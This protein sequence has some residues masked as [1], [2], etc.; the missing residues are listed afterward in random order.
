MDEE[1]LFRLAW[2]QAR[3]RITSDFPTLTAIQPETAFPLSGLFRVTAVAVLFQQGAHLGLEE[4]QVWSRLESG[5]SG[6]TDTHGSGQ[7]ENT[8]PKR[9]SAVSLILDTFGTTQ[10]SH[11]Q[12]GRWISA[13]MCPKLVIPTLF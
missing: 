5:R 1:T 9:T 12:L 2:H 13:R 8:H 7:N 6:K 4:G 11:L 10:W 3:A